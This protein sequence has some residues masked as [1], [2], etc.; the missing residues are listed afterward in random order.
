MGES[1]TRPSFGYEIAAANRRKD[2]PLV[3]VIGKQA[4]RR[5]LESLGAPV[6]RHH[7]VLGSLREV[8]PSHLTEP[9]VLKPV[10][11]SSSHGVA[12]LV[13]DGSGRGWHDVLAGTSE[14]FEELIARLEGIARKRRVGEQWLVEE[15]LLHPDEDPRPANDVKVYAFRGEIGCVLLQRAAPRRYRWFDADWTPVDVGKY[16]DR[17]DETLAPQDPEGALRLA[18][19]ISSALPIPF[20]RVDLYDSSRGLV[21]GELTPLPGKADRFDPAWDEHLGTLYER[22]ESRLLTDMLD[23]RKHMPRRSWRAVRHRAEEI[24]TQYR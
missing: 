18:A 8:T 12:A 17:I 23:W 19:D 21:V 22:A 7:D 1:L 13:P 6:P 3:A 15:L 9:R 2:N 11:G 4:A 10:S 24:R 14:T 20:M 5:V 16:R